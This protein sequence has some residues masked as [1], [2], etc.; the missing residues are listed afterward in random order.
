MK[1][2]NDGM[3]NQTPQGY[4]NFQQMMAQQRYPQQQGGGP[5][6]PGPFP[7]APNLPSPS[8]GPPGNPQQQQHFMQLQMQRNQQLQYQQMQMHQHHQQHPQYQQQQP[9][10]QQQQKRNSFTASTSPN[11]VAGRRPSHGGAPA[12]SPRAK[13]MP[14]PVAPPLYQP[15][16]S[17]AAATK[18][19]SKAAMQQL[20]SKTR[21]QP[22]AQPPAS[23][24]SV[25]PLMSA[26]AQPT[27]SGATQAA[28]SSSKRDS[29]TAVP[30]TS[31]TSTAS[32]ASIGPQ[33]AASI[34]SAAQQKNL[35]NQCD[36]KEKTLWATRQILGG[37]S[38]NGF[39][40]SAA[41]A[42]RIK[43]QR[44]RQQASTKKSAAAA[45]AA[46]A[47]G[48]AGKAVPPGGAGDASKEAKKV[49][50]DQAAEEQLKK[51]IMN[52]RTAKKIKSEFEAGIQFCITLHNVVRGI[53]FEVDPSQ[54]PHLPRVLKYDDDISS[55]S[56]SQ[57]SA[58]LGAMT[59][60]SGVPH[61]MM[62]PPPTTL[63]QLNNSGK[64]PA[65]KNGGNMGL[66]GPSSM[67]GNQ[68]RQQLQQQQRLKQLQQR[69]S[70][71]ASSKQKSSGGKAG[72]AVAAPTASPGNPSGSS[73]RKNRKKKLPPSGAPAVQ[74]SEFDSS[75]KR[76]FSKKDHMY[77]IFQVLRFRPLKQGDFVAARLSSR[78]LWI[79]ATVLKNYSGPNIAPTEFLLLTDS[80]RDGLFREKVLV[81]DVEDKD[82]RGSQNQV[83]RNLILPLP[84][85]YSEAAEWAQRLVTPFSNLVCECVRSCPLFSSGSSLQCAL[86]VFT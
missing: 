42:Q 4:Q 11:N 61:N 71:T 26:P 53:I 78:D 34:A 3:A 9:Q 83:A 1:P 10:Q 73:L 65:N 58:A 69:T 30:R 55:S 59:T 20:A 66:P 25:A 23:A 29:F 82:H 81:K 79:L 77:R 85:G 43:K 47:A 64:S 68:T 6:F 2:A 12:P 37:N 36:W 52:P 75:G 32:M 39:L 41:T 72:K 28:T 15:P 56:S 80:R 22:M 7:Q 8:G 49:S 21:P 70:I 44:A 67:Q 5:P 74:L 63:N 33:S 17:S 46:A 14:A 18:S 31:L 19:Q 51:D 57:P 62:P 50:F 54:S 24:T 13:G 45:A 86:L 27:A 16:Q 76:L 84:R 38:I 35:L 48:A 40:R 60:A